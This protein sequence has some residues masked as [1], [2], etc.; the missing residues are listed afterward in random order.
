MAS[1][2]ERLIL[3][4][5]SPVRARLLRAAGIDFIVQPSTIDESTIKRR[6][7]AEGRH[8]RDCACALAEAKAAEISPRYRQS[9]VIG[10]DQILVCG[11]EWF[12]KPADLA[13]ARRQLEA[14][15][16]RSHVLETA[17]CAV[18]AGEL[19]W[20]AASAPQLTMRDFG[21]VFLDGYLAREGDAILGSVGAY[22]LERRGVQ[23]FERIEGD[24]F[25]I[26]GLPLTPLLGFL[27]E[28]G[29]LA[30]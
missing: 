5:A 27:R 23:L 29:Q 11:A 13:A 14:L 21:E 6:F 2:S 4:S 12:D 10:A 7:R 9:V 19:L 1:P 30:R 28:Q 17:A 18:R 26:L 3:A 16:G 20:I 8:P 25:A 22:R 15:R 24:Y